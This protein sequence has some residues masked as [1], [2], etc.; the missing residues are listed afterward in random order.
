[1]QK[2]NNFVRRYFINNIMSDLEIILNYFFDYTYSSGYA[3]I[4]N[5]NLQLNENKIVN[6]FKNGTYG[7]LKVCANLAFF[8][9]SFESKLYK[10]LKFRSSK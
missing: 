2:K 8:V 4:E 9:D 1:M 7:K 6:N 5:K 3:N 10:L